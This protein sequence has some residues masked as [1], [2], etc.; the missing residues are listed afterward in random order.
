MR[1]MKKSSL[2]FTFALAFSTFHASAG[3]GP[4]IDSQGQRM[5][6]E[7]FIPAFDAL[8]ASY[9]F[10]NDLEFDGSDAEL[11]S[12]RFGLVS[13]LTKPIDL[14]NSWN[15]LSVV[16]YKITL[17]DFTDTP[18]GFPMD[19]EE[20][21]KIGLHATVY[22]HSPGSRWIYGGWGRASFASDTQHIDGDD[23]YFDL[24]LGGGY[25]VSDR[26]LLGLGVVGLELG[27]DEH[28]LAGPGFYWKPTDEFDFS[29][30]G[31]LFNATWR[32]S[33][34]WAL[35]LRVRPFGN[36]W[37]I[38]NGGASQQVDLSS[39]TVRLHAERRVY[40]DLWLSLGVGYAFANELELRDSSNDRIFKEDLGGGVS[41]SIGLRI[42][43]W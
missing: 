40:R 6:P 2:G 35:A 15:L 36:S 41:S 32:P 9:D 7:S 18:A 20:L 3:C 24:A 23:F 38:D 11:D 22:R 26:F 1:S 31:V 10:Q 37:N 43:T 42:R 12:S 28:L 16:E 14:G 4:S 13:L 21:H 39:Y 30:M 25:M 19:D 33:N 29:M 8:S 27:S 17:L 5:M 34:D